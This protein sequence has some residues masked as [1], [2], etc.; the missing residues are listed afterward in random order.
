VDKRQKDTQAAA[1]RGCKAESIS[2]PA[3]RAPG[4]TAKDEPDARTTSDVGA[5]GRREAWTKGWAATPG[6][7]T[8]ISAEKE[9]DDKEIAVSPPRDRL[10]DVL[11]EDTKLGITT[12]SECGV[13]VITAVANESNASRVGVLPGSIIRA[14]HG[15]Y[16]CNETDQ[17]RP[18]TIQHDVT[19]YSEGGGKRTSRLDVCE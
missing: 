12:R 1:G 10:Y 2:S 16:R 18:T 17:R 9:A 15:A 4:T 19:R 8:P 3:A 7:G 13:L 6:G 5:S 14:R 11:F